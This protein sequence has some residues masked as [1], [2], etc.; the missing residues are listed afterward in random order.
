MSRLRTQAAT[1]V[2]LIL[3][4]S[5]A[6]VAQSV[7][8]RLQKLEDQN[9]QLQDQNSRIM[10][11]LQQ[12]EMR[13][14]TLEQRLGA[15]DD[16][17]QRKF[18]LLIEQLGQNFDDL[19]RGGYGGGG[20]ISR[21]GFALQFYGTLR[22]EAAY[23]DSRFNRTVDPQWV[24]SEDDI[25]AEDDDDQF[26]MD[27]RRSTIGLNTDLGDIMGAHVRGKLEFD[28]ASF[29]N[30]E[31]ESVAGV[32]LLFAWID[33]DLGNG[34]SLRFG[35]DWDLIAPLDPIVDNQRHLWD[36]GNLGDRRPQAQFFYQ[37]GSRESVEYSFGV[38][39]GLTGAIDNRDY[40]VGF[41]TFL[42]TE[43]DGFDS[44]QP[45]IQVAASVS[46]D[47]WVDDARI[48]LGA[49]FAWARL[50]T[51][52]K[53]IDEDHFTTW[54]IAIDFRIPILTGLELRGEAFMGQALGDFRG[55][56]SQSINVTLGKE[57]DSKGGWAE[58]QWQAT[59]LFSIAV[60]GSI[61][62]PDEDDLEI[63][64]RASNWTLYVATRFDWGDGLR[65]GIDGMFWKTQYVSRDDGDAIRISAFVELAF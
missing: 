1:S 48:Q 12:A 39:L 42:S 24:R 53:F 33:L 26:V 30:G 44:G 50:E 34:F 21:S 10:Q 57:I 15:A 17:N 63:A 35:Q 20:S 54:L 58:L 25:V 49:S 61:D 40:D 36:T 13:N 37:G 41:G 43:R 18:D 38:S 62:N 47:S 29:D 14:A 64:A 7:E 4:L 2:M 11:R 60:G 52:T 16:F 46:F 19:G 9:R 31:S 8:D 5:S 6:L 45:N 51:D 3:L 55:G 65:S 56:I 28:F 23:S 32:R 22:W 27:V 59:D